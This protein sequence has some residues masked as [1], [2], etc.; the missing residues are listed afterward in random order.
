MGLAPK[1]PSSGDSSVTTDANNFPLDA[2]SN[3]M[4][5]LEGGMIFMGGPNDSLEGTGPSIQASAFAEFV[6]TNL[7]AIA[8]GLNMSYELLARDFTQTNFSSARQSSLEDKRH[9]EPRQQLLIDRLCDPVFQWFVD[10]CIMA[11]IQ[12]FSANEKRIKVEWITPPREY[13]DPQK[14]VE[15]DIKAIQAG[16]TNLQKIASKHGTD[17]HENIRLNAQIGKEAEEQ[18]LTLASVTAKEEPPPPPPVI[19]QP[20]QIDTDNGNGKDKKNLPDRAIFS[21]R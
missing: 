14:E 18:D 19:E 9:W 15:A 3:P 12:P 17:V 10:A 2:N 16:F 5:Y 21:R 20:G 4:G 6:A 11:G 7:R 8:T 1:F 13:V